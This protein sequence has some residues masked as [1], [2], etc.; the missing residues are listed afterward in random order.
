M[1][2]HILRIISMAVVTG[3][4]FL[5]QI[6]YAGN[7]LPVGYT[8]QAGAFKDV[9]KAGRFTDAL[10]ARNLDATCYIKDNGLFAV[11]FGDFA[12]WS[13]ADKTARRLK[14]EKM[15]EQFYI[16][17][18]KRHNKVFSNLSSSGE[19]RPQQT[20]LGKI[21]AQ[22]AARFTGIPYHWGGNNVVE[23]MDCSGFV[24]AVYYL[25]G[26]NIPRTSQEQYDEG[27]AVET[28]QIMEGD[29][30]FFGKGR[31]KI[32]HVGLYLGNNQFV[33][34]PR[35][36]EPIQVTSLKDEKYAV[37]FVGVRRYL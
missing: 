32:S 8:I 1:K 15:I 20:A 10:K 34:A 33:H 9:L 18:P 4:L 24:K 12:T 16:V 2:N 21:A 19:K 28:D 14:S 29:L 11:V 35:R 30:V 13:E 25:V 7:T 26:L 27:V 31:E 17:A 3:M 36:G 5:S 22:T 37:K 23:G 6:V